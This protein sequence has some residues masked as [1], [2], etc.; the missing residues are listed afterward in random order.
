MACETGSFD[1]LI[2]HIIRGCED[3]SQTIKRSLDTTFENPRQ[4]LQEQKE[5]FEHLKME[6]LE[7]LKSLEEEQRK[8]WST[9]F[10]RLQTEYIK[11]VNQHKHN[12]VQWKKNYSNQ[13]KNMQECIEKL[14]ISTQ[15]KFQQ[16]FHHANNDNNNNNNNNNNN[17]RLYVNTGTH[18]ELMANK[19]V[20]YQFYNNLLSEEQF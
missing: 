1:G 6:Q 4:Y 20:D 19:S 14:K 15:L 17:I 3:C 18:N 13:K 9:T 5:S 12:L 8:V 7:N 11:I 10:Q 2:Q 16:L